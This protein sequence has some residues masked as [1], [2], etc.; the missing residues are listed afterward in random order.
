MNLQKG[1]RLTDLET[2]PMV[3]GRGGGEIGG[4]G[5]LGSWRRPYCT[6]QRTLLS[7]MWQPGW[8]GVWGRMAA[9]LCMAESF[10][11]SPEA[12]MSLLIG[13]TPTQNKK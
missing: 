11:C 7:V 6:A 10:H 9:C 4:T 3:A 13:Y 5:Q 12:I 8:R 2:E 1:K